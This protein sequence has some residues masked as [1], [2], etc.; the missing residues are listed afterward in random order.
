MGRTKNGK[1]AVLFDLDG[2]V[3][4]SKEGI[5]NSLR[6]TFSRIGIGEQDEAVMQKFI[7]PSIG[8]MMMELYGLSL[9][10]A[11]EAVKIYRQY[12]AEKGIYECTPYENI[13]ELFRELQKN[14]ILVAIAT[15]KPEMFTLR[16]M[17]WLGFSANTNCI[18]G[19]S[20]DDHGNSKA[21]IIERAVSEL[22]VEKVDAVMVGDTLYDT[23]GAREAGVDFI[24]VL[25][26]FGD[27]KSMEKEGGQKFAATVAELKEM[28]I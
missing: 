12:Y 8:G 26:G 22:G 15:K 13:G 4:N 6:Y 9:S 2:T 5:F 18:C 17:D 24:G 3:I 28:L 11:E 27:K 20:K 7:G 25:Y 1:R 19:A 21:S 10:E 23:V 16:I 14:D